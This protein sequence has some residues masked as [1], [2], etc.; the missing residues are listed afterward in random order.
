MSDDLN[1]LLRLAGILKE[2]PMPDEFRRKKPD[3]GSKRDTFNLDKD[4]ER[5]LRAMDKEDGFDEYSMDDNDD[6]GL[7][8]FDTAM[9]D[10]I[11][12]PSYPGDEN[13]NEYDFSTDDSHIPDVGDEYDWDDATSVDDPSMLFNGSKGGPESDE[14]S[15][16]QQHPYDDGEDDGALIYPNDDHSFEPHPEFDEA[17]KV[18]EYEND[19]EAQAGED[20][21]KK[22][23][24]KHKER[25]K[26]RFDDLAGEEN[27]GED[28]LAKYGNLFDEQQDERATDEGG[29]FEGGEHDVNLDD[30]IAKIL[31]NINDITYIGDHT[32]QYDAEKFLASAGCDVSS[33]D[34]MKDSLSKLGADELENICDRLCDRNF[35][36]DISNGYDNIKK[37]DAEEHFPDGAAGPATKKAGPTSARNGDNPM[38]VSIKLES[39]KQELTE[40]YK[41]Y[42]K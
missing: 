14:F 40:S 26:S 20:Y 12:R 37:Y 16:E 2:N 30:I 25:S 8:N 39:I 24:A 6:L 27:D 11:N 9:Y 31:Y 13:E 32:Q 28:E 34:T 23:A 5:L 36:E 22:Y 17:T 18:V 4:S 35:S 38:A 1:N 3:I 42:K 19:E 10:S 7:P 29:N 41:K 33:I 15:D 21:F